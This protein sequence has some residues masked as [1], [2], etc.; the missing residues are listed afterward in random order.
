M[1]FFSKF[2][3][4]AEADVLKLVAAI[5]T[6][7][8]V[9]QADLDKAVV[10]ATAQAPAIASTLESVGKMAAEVG[11]ITDPKVG[12]ALAAAQTMVTALNAIAASHNGG[13]GNVAAV[14]HGYVAVKQAQAAVSAA[15]V[16]VASGPNAAPAH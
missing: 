11:M 12:L 6:G 2:F 4:A 5:K 15:A 10:W 16:A 1:S 14:V 9:F 7:E 8:Q 13:A 3:E